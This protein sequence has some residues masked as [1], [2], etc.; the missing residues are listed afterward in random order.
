MRNERRDWLTPAAVLMGTVAV[1]VTVAWASAQDRRET[2]R[3]RS[4]IERV[5]SDLGQVRLELKR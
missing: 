4:A 2:Q 3:V 1:C 5:E